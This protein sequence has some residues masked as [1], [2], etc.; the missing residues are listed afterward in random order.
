MDTHIYTPYL[1]YGDDLKVV[2]R[3][4]IQSSDP[5]TTVFTLL[6]VIVF[7]RRPLPPLPL[8]V[9][10]KHI[11]GTRDVSINMTESKIHM[12]YLKSQIRH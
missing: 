3:V 5:R 8:R 11:N 12:S 4:F 1:P 7:T 9:L 2:E 10:E 6:F